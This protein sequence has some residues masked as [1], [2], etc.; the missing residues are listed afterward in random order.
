M[1]DHHFR[2]Y[3]S[4]RKDLLNQETSNGINTT[5]DKLMFGSRF[6]I[7]TV[8]TTDNLIQHKR[9]S[10][11]ILLY[12]SLDILHCNLWSAFRFS[13]CWSLGTTPTIRTY[14]CRM[15]PFTTVLSPIYKLLFKYILTHHCQHLSTI[16]LSPQS[17]MFTETLTVMKHLFSILHKTKDEN[18]VWVDFWASQIYLIVGQVSESLPSGCEG[19]LSLNIAALKQ[20]LLCCCRYFTKPKTVCGWNSITV[21]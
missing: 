21:S 14:H 16:V 13:W 11:N 19:L 15:R 20:Q 6:N 10:L 2:I 12:I 9:H 7:S 8:E 5:D 17:V 1:Y 4:D 18:R 3:I